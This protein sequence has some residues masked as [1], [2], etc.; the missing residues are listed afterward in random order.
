VYESISISTSFSSVVDADAFDAS[1]GVSRGAVFF[2]DLEL[3]RVPVPAAFCFK[4]WSCCATI[5]CESDSSS[6]LRGS[7]TGR[8]AGDDDNDDD[9]DDDVTD[10][11]RARAGAA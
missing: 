3:A 6:W 5:N 1:L 4:T 8:G 10:E 2:S 11:R 7:G 9:N